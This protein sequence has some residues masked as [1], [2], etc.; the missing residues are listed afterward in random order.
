MNAT[1]TTPIT[2]LETASIGARGVGG[3]GGGLYS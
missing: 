2:V 1:E 3:G